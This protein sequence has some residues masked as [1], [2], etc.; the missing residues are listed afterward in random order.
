MTEIGCRYANGD[1]G[2]IDQQEY[3]AVQTEPGLE[4]DDRGPAKLLAL[5]RL[6]KPDIR[7]RDKGEIALPQD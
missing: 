2:Q 7:L 5:Q 6:S 3:P 1:Y 4:R